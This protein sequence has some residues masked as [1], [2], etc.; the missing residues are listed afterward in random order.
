VQA[1]QAGNLGFAPAAAQTATISVAPKALT[2]TANNASRAYGAAN[3][4]NPG[5]T[6]PALAGSDS[7]ASV[8]Y[9]YAAGATAT[10][11]VGT[12]YSITPSAALFGSG[13]AAN[14]LISYVAGTLTI[15]GTA[16]QSV[17]FAPPA[18][19]TYGDAPLT[20][21]AK[22]SSGLPITFTLVSGPATL[23]GSTLTLTGAG[24]VTVRASQGGN[25]D[26]AA[27]ADVTGSISVAPKALTI[28][29]NNASRAYGAANPANPG[30]SSAGL[31][32]GDGIAAVSYSYPAAASATASVGT[33]Y[34]ITPGSAVFSAGSAANYLIRYLPGTLTVTIPADAV[35][36]VLTMSTLSSGALTNNPVLNVSGTAGDSYGIKSLTVNGSLVSVAADGSFS[37]SLVLAPGAN[38]V[39]TVATS[40][41]TLS[42]TDTRS[43]TL[44]ATAP[45]LTVTAPADN[46]VTNQ[47]AVTVAG[48]VSETATVTARV[49]GGNW[50]TAQMNGTGFSI[51]LALPEGQNTIELNATDLAGNNLVTTVKRTVTVDLS[52]P[53]LAVTAP[54]QDITTG[55]GSYLL[56]G[57]T[58]D[59]DSA[60]G[61][62]VSMDG[63][64][65]TPTVS[66]GT[67]SQQLA[68][69]SQKQYAVTVT[70][71]DQA[72]NSATVQRNIT[73]SASTAVTGD[74]TGDVNGDGTVDLRDV[75][76]ALRISI[77]AVTPTAEQL[78]RGDVGPLAGG[79]P[80][81][82][83]T[84]DISDAVVIME[85]SL[86]LVSW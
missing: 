41:S 14:Y 31:A 47:S 5:F 86:G 50:Q 85:R 16:G 64:T 35:K 38:T 40:N 72:G 60:V 77:G 3:P 80:A 49:G 6:A 29:A 26:Y 81:P 52:K 83:G 20:L 76:L 79:K 37:G 54:S 22:A 13:S 17:S 33:S 82:D 21:S 7:I 55:Q 69:S 45:T 11:T 19:A 32:G 27:A 43:I 74:T 4:A 62:T 23:N 75:L 24:T 84:I 28:T 39:T 15:A 67:F 8:T 18:T 71:T 42:T 12:T 59:A 34:G 73:Y 48:K 9:S 56:T 70:A 57:T 1:N 30:F 44:D 78:A 53:S 36:P 58:S 46:S 68:F 2:I 25:V 61:V 10:A 66:A 51:L 65:Y 63:K